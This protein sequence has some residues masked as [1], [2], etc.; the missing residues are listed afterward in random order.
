MK[1]DV[2]VGS[3]KPNDVPGLLSP[4]V[5]DPGG[6]FEEQEEKKEI[7]ILYPL[8]QE[9]VK[10]QGGG[11]VGWAFV[12]LDTVESRSSGT[13]KPLVVL[14]DD[15]GLHELRSHGDPTRLHWNVRFNGSKLVVEPGE[16][17]LVTQNTDTPTAKIEDNSTKLAFDSIARVLSQ[18]KSP[19]EV[20]KGRRQ[21]IVALTEAEKLTPEKRLE[22]AQAEVW[23]LHSE[24][25]D[26]AD[27]AMAAALAKYKEASGK[28]EPKFMQGVG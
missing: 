15:S 27:P 23:K 4:L 28:D 25:V 3:V 13:T 24:G 1:M 7:V 5:A 6:D 22:I 26:R 2:S 18:G 11:R 16:P 14:L 9:V 12:G 21:P 19:I 17:A 10:A 20:T 8:A